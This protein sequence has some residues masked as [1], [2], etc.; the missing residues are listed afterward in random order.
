[1]IYLVTDKIGGGKSLLMLTKILEHLGKG[2]CVVSNIALLELEVDKWLKRHRGRRL[3]AD[4]VQFHDFEEEPRFHLKIPFGVPSLP[5]MVVCDEA[6]LYY[7]SADAARLQAQ[8]S[9]LVSFLTQSRKC[10]VDV[11]FVTQHDTTIW[12]QFRHQALFG[13]KC[14]D[15]RSVSLPFIGQVGALG[16]CWV[17][18]DVMSGE[19]MERGR[20][21]LSKDLFGLYD[22]RQMFD[23]QMRELRESA[24]VWQPVPKNAKG[25]YEIAADHRPRRRWLEL[26]RL[27]SRELLHR[28]KDAPSSSESLQG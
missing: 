21:P 6:Q 22:T 18:F 16:L 15:M 26:L 27:E 7:N 2:G 13:F 12:A 9:K 28:E 10:C 1:M 8:Y 20:T 25:K 19:I 11:W 14:R 3:V 24:K 23:S 17:K 4:Q 5:V